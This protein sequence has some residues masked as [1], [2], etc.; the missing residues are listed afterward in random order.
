MLAAFNEVL[1]QIGPLPQVG[2]PWQ[3]N[4]A[5]DVILIG[6]TIFMIAGVWLWARSGRSK[7]DNN[8]PFDRTA[9]SFAGTVFAGYGPLPL[10]LVVM[11]ATILTAMV[12][13]TIVSILSG[14]QY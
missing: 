9:E 8:V 6:T 2:R 10:F 5:V 14:T 4:W 12:L 11:Y 3:E 7:A 1:Y 13:Y